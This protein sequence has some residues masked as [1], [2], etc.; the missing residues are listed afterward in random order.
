MKFVANEDLSLHSLKFEDVNSMM[1][2]SRQFT[3]E[4]PEDIFYPQEQRVVVNDVFTD[5]DIAKV[6]AASKFNPVEKCPR[7]GTKKAK[8]KVNGKRG[9]CGA[10][11]DPSFQD[12]LGEA[13]KMVE[14]S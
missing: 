2:L 6:L 10:R 4:A 13:I 7:A 14:N 3:S 1:N 8:K 9:K 11:P 12:I 5:K